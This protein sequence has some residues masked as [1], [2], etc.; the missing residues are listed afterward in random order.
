[1]KDRS[2]DIATPTTPQREA[3]RLGSEE[4]LVTPPHYNTRTTEEEVPLTP[5][6][7]GS[8][9]SSIDGV[10]AFIG[11]VTANALDEGSED[12]SG[13][14]SD[15]SLMDIRCNSPRTV[16]GDSDSD[17]ITSNME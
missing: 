13:Y 15:S 14:G 16:I 1:M 17:S 5:G 4:E 10:S 6:T 7:P 11:F 3:S 12:E 2:M 9:T 8:T